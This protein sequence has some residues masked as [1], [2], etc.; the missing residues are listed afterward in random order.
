MT[1]FGVELAGSPPADAASSRATTSR[2]SLAAFGAANEL[3]R[4]TDDI[5]AVFGAVVRPLFPGE[6]DPCG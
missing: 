2:P 3:T 4:W 5:D 1:Q 6:P